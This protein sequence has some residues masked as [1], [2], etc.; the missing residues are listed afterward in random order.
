MIQL[1]KH[2][3]QIP[4]LLGLTAG[5]TLGSGGRSCVVLPVLPVAG[6][7]VALLDPLGLQGLHPLLSTPAPG[8]WGTLRALVRVFIFPD[9]I[10][11]VL[12]LRLASLR[13]EAPVVS[14]LQGVDVM[15]VSVTQGEPI[16]QA[17]LD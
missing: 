6:G 13:A 9:P 8:R 7:V 3:S 16:G 15:V 5:L 2:D 11:H 4:G 12:P 14:P 17:R 1:C 10:A